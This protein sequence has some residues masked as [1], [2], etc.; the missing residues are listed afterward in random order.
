M[1]PCMD[2]CIA[3]SCWSTSSRTA[4]IWVG[5]FVSRAAWSRVRSASIVAD[6]ACDCVWH[7][8]TMSA[9]TDALCLLA[10]DC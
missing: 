4:R 5:F 3:V 7:A 1:P 2:S 8:V 9:L 6:G 10:C